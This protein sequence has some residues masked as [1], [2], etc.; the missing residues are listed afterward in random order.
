M[1]STQTKQ[2]LFS[3]SFW[4]DDFIGS[5]SRD[6]RHFFQYLIT[7]P[8]R[9]VSGIYRSSYRLMQFHDG[10]TPEEV[11]Q[12]FET[13]SKAGKAFFYRQEWVIIING[14]TH[15][16]FA[17]ED[18]R[19]NGVANMFLDTPKDVQLFALENGY[20]WD[21]IMQHV[22]PSY[23][24]FRGSGAELA[25]KLRGNNPSKGSRRVAKG[26]EGSQTLNDPGEHINL[27]SNS[28]SN[29][30]SRKSKSVSDAAHPKTGRPMS[31][32]TYDSLT[33]QFDPDTVD[34]YFERVA[35]H[36]SSR[37]KRYK[38]HAA[39]VRNWLKR[40]NVP[41]RSPRASPGLPDDPDFDALIARQYQEVET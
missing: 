27:N 22:S 21:H 20:M 14:P 19:W 33:T 8:E 24:G 3:T 34:D 1:A 41:K 32:A 39:T 35:D 30:N 5:L 13:L 25:E 37:G 12:H 15:H 23:K 31:Q 38:D 9:N 16:K 36:E 11:D 2:T 7:A 4:I 17:D 26:S 40:D 18:N 29:S 10:W 6:C 28:N